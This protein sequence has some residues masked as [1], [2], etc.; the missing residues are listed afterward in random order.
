MSQ[1]EKKKSPLL[2]E[3]RNQL[4]LFICNILD[5]TPKDDMGS[6]EHPMFTLEKKPDLEIRR[7][8]HNGNSI[9]VEP[10][11]LGHATIFDKDVL[12]YAISQLRAA[13]NDGREIS[14]TLR[15]TAYDYLK[16]TNRTTSGADYNR[17]EKSLKRLKGTS[18]TTNI[19]TNEKTI[20]KG[21]GLMDS[22]EVV[23]ENKSGKMEAIEITL[24]E[25]LYN[26]ILGKEVLSIHPDY[27]RLAKSLERRIYELA[28]KHCGKQ[29]EWEI[30]LKL[31]HKKTGS[32][33]PLREFRRMVK[34]IEETDHLPE[35]SMNYT[36]LPIDKVSFQ[37]RSRQQ[38]KLL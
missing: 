18:V 5:A 32:S 38:Q 17:M 33:A 4:D 6:M 21:F 31:L 8:E 19:K 1:L 37:L 12:I 30:G 2:P 3:R 9:V 20:S 11:V 24:S 34:A 16:A 14:K 7:Y 29:P 26:A 10:S 28:R 13:L 35:Y 25:W 15:L 36:P 27:F 23:K 22:W